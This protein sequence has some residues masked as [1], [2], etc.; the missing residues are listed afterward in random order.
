MLVGQVRCCRT[1][2]SLHAG[3]QQHVAHPPTHPPHVQ[4]IEAQ[5]PRVPRA[6]GVTAHWLCIH[7][8]QP[9]IPENAPLPSLAA[10]QAPAGG[11]ADQRQQ[12]TSSARPGGHHQHSFGWF[13][14]HINAFKLFKLLRTCPHRV[15]AAGPAAA[16]TTVIPAAAGSGGGVAVAAPVRLSR[17]AAML[18]LPP[19]T[20][21]CAWPLN[22][23]CLTRAG[24]ACAEPRAGG[25]L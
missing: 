25:V 6:V 24:A 3:S 20:A 11:L 1:L 19:C 12:A 22:W 10:R 17:P 2:P 13:C 16:H 15:H 4:V 7:G 5:L 9:A 8:Q 18:L 14:H 23:T 21:E